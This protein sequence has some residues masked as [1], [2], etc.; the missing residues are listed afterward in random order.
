LRGIG[1]RPAAVMAGSMGLA[2]LF[3]QNQK[4]IKGKIYFL[5]DLSPSA[6]EVLALRDGATAYTRE[7]V[8]SDNQSW[9]DLLLC[10]AEETISKMRLSPE[11]A[12]ERILLAGESSESAFAEIREDIPDC[13]LI[14]KHIRGEIPEETKPFIQEAAA[15]LGLA[16][17]GLARRP[18]IGINL[19]P[20]EMK[21]RQT[22]WAYVPAAILG[23]AILALLIALGFHK[24]VQERK[25][26]LELDRQI[27]LLKGPVETVQGLK[28][29]SETL[30]NRSQS[31]TNLLHN[32]D[33]NLEILLELTTILPTD[34]YLETYSNRDG[35]IQIGGRSGSAYDLMPKL[36][37]SPILKDV[38]QKGSIFKDAATGR[39]RFSFEM[40]LEK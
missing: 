16:C 31:I 35:L 40:K 2:N 12:V 36:E 39:D 15:A 19:L 10:E 5:A 34:T 14:K 26:I 32:R 24:I 29:Q 21:I 18:A 37:K 1:L 6:F 20:A 17:V 3:L 13:E 25:L 23:L 38:V 4:D 33:R 27:G 30:Q 8:K 9:K 7:A 22:R 11:S 28:E